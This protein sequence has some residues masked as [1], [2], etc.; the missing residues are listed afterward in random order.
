MGNRF[1]SPQYKKSVKGSMSEIAKGRETT[2]KRCLMSVFIRKNH[3]LPLKIFNFVRPRNSCHSPNTQGTCPGHHRPRA[4]LV[5]AAPCCLSLPVRM[6]CAS[7][8]CEI[9]TPRVLQSEYRA[10]ALAAYTSATESHSP[11]GNKG[12]HF[13]GKKIFIKNHFTK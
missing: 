4:V 12:F 6:Q 11:S 13:P 2:F 7:V 3:I 1:A 9:F 10:C 8:C 5:P